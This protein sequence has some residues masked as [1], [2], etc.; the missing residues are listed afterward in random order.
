MKRSVSGV[1]AAQLLRRLGWREH[2]A[3]CTDGRGRKV[4]IVLRRQTSDAIEMD[5]PGGQR[6]RLTHTQAGRLRAALRVVLL[7]HHQTHRAGAA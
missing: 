4:T 6:I 2:S 3:E 1:P 5:L 7:V